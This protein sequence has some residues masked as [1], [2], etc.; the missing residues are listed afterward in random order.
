M[1]HRVK[2]GAL[3]IGLLG[4]AACNDTV[5]LESS[6]EDSLTLDVAMFAADAAIDEFGDLGFLF[7]SRALP[8]P[9]AASTRNVTRTA[10]FFDADGNAQDTRDPLTTASIHLTIES[11]HEFSRDSW[12]GTGTRSKRHGDLGAQGRG[13]ESYRERNRKRPCDS[14]PAHGRGR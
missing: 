12:S 3:A 6:F 4:L 11:T 14:E 5:G 7:G 9:G 10:T 13:D 8:A 2:S 1:K